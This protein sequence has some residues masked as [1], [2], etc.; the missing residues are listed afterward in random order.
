MT[1]LGERKKDAFNERVTWKVNNELDEA[2]H[3]C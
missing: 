2:D 3:L 1:R